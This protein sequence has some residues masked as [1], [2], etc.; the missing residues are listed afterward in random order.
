VGG[1]KLDDPARFLTTVACS[2]VQ[3]RATKFDGVCNANHAEHPNILLLIYP[4]IC[5]TRIR[6]NSKWVGLRGGA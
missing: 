6:G 3:P 2:A 4:H 5:V 1:H